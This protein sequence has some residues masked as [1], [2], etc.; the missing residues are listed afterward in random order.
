MP[1]IHAQKWEER[2]PHGPPVRALCF[3][4]NYYDN[5]ESL[6]NCE[7]D[8]DKIVNGVRSLSDGRQGKCVAK[9]RKGPQLKDKRAMKSAVIDFLRE[10]D[11]EA[12][13]R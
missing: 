4:I 13:P 9:L 5:L 10:I 1:P 7:Q 11:K 12:P 3:G 2:L 8:A 6:S